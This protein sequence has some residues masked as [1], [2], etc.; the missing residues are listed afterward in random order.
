MAKLRWKKIDDESYELKMGEETLYLD[1]SIISSKWEY[2][3]PGHFHGK[4]TGLEKA[5]RDSIIDLKDH[6]SSHSRSLMR[7]KEE[8]CKK[9]KNIDSEFGEILLLRFHCERLGIF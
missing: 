2:H 5:K 7:E 4:A 3:L 9:L 8:V 6:I 1:R